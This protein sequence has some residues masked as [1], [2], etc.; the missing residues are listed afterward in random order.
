MGS[1]IT[2]AARGISASIDAVKKLA[3]LAI[4][5]RNVEL[6]EGILAVKEQLLEAKEALLNSREDI[7]VLKEENRE[8]KDRITELEKQS[9]EKLVVRDDGY[10]A[11]NGEGP[12]CTRC[13][14]VQD[15]KLEK[16]ARK[17]FHEI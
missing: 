12:F 17:R 10:Y 8:L 15:K 9:E 13:Y 3:E 4:K 16:I 11:Q 6:Q 14:L 2:T 7:L 1:D 5:S